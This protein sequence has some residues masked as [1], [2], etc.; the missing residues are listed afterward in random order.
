MST[1]PDLRLAAM[2]QPEE[3]AALHAAG[4][5]IR[6]DVGATL[7]SEGEQTDHVVLIKAGRVKV[8][9][10]GHGGQE[11][12][13][14]IRG[15]GDMVGE[16]SPIDGA[17]RSATA[18]AITP[19]E[20]SVVRAGDFKAFLLG[21]PHV[22][23]LLLVQMAGRLRDADR[24]RVDIVTTGVAS[25]VARCLLDLARADVD[26]VGRPT[27][28]VSDV[29]QQEIAALVGASREAV[30]KALQGF[31]LGGLIELARRHVAIID[32]EGLEALTGS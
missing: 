22:Q 31:R 13:L 28:L 20:A 5:P 30:S 3:R 19:V 9:S 29:S 27:P 4:I 2:L 23:W 21:H 18:V 8:V 7:F 26:N 6:Y 12:I 10:A 11:V 25:R 17:S 15:P 24:R 14:G 1:A 32:P 16:M